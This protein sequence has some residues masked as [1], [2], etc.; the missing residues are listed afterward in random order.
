MFTYWVKFV[1]VSAAAAA[2]V[3]NSTPEARLAAPLATYRAG[4]DGVGLNSGLFWNSYPGN[5][6]A[7]LRCFVLYVLYRLLERIGSMC[8]QLPDP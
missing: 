7:Q 1:P 8:S 5:L 2:D 3:A 4:V 6:V